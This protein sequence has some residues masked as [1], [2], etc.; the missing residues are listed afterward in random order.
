MYRTGVFALAALLVG[1]AASAALSAQTLERMQMNYAQRT[2][3]LAGISPVIWE[4]DL[5]SVSV[6]VQG[7]TISILMNIPDFGFSLIVPWSLSVPLPD[8]PTSEIRRI[9]VSLVHENGIVDEPIGLLTTWTLASQGQ[10]PIFY[11][12][13]EGVSRSGNW[14]APLYR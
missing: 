13:F 10:N 1:T 7:N 9:T 14:P 8:L 6:S 2:V 5:A 12:S 3:D 11:S 4:P